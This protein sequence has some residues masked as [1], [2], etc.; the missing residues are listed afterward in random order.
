MFRT[1]VPTLLINSVADKY[2]TFYFESQRLL[3]SFGLKPTGNTLVSVSYY[4]K[5]ILIIKKLSIISFKISFYPQKI[6][7][8]KYYLVIS[9]MVNIRTGRGRYQPQS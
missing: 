5:Y 2:S 7:N 3:F 9:N 6:N 4:L 8:K 1:P